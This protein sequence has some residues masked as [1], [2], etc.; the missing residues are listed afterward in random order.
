MEVDPVTGVSGLESKLDNIGVVVAI[1]LFI[2]IV[3]NVRYLHTA[4]QTILVITKQL[5][6]AVIQYTTTVE[7]VRIN[8]EAIKKIN[9][10]LS[11][12]NVR[13]RDLVEK[14]HRET[15]CN[16]ARIRMFLKNGSE[17]MYECDVNGECIWANQSLCD[18]FGL[19]Y[20]DMMGHGWMEAIPP[21]QRSIVID[22]W[23][24][25]IRDDI[26]YTWSYNII[27][28]ITSE[29]IRVTATAIAVRDEFGHPILHCG[30]V[31]KAI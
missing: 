3:S 27:N 16:T 25:A 30:I 31:K 23:N 19:A 6:T 4:L 5:V 8:Y 24:K 2:V 11:I 21:E 9:N 13:V 1:L 10:E 12:N 20:H 26:P 22:I 17:G 29:N 28:R 15:L 7:Q 18:L 14:T